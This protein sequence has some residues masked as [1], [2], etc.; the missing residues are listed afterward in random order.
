MATMGQFQTYLKKD[1]DFLVIVL[2]IFQWK[3]FLEIV[4]HIYND[5]QAISKFIKTLKVTNFDLL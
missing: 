3:Y 4:Y 1:N 5:E 2:Y